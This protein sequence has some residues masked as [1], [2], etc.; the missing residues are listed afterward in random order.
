MNF[1]IGGVGGGLSFFKEIV[2]D[3]DPFGETDKPLTARGRVQADE[4]P[5]RIEN[6]PGV[7]VDVDACEPRDTPEH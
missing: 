2:D 6:V 3:F 7:T 5:G 4:L 1:E